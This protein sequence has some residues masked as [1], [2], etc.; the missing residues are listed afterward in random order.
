M[1]TKKKHYYVACVLV[2]D[3]KGYRKITTK[4]HW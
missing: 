4:I 3:L 2:C 1:A